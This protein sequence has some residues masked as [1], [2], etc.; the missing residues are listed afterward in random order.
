MEE[1]PIFIY[2]EIKK[3]LSDSFLPEDSEVAARCPTG[4]DKVLVPSLLRWTRLRPSTDTTTHQ[5]R[6]E[7]G[8]LFCRATTLVYPLFPLSFSPGRLASCIKLNMLKF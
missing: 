7:L 4:S 2:R 3:K 5:F 8:A 6:F 1:H